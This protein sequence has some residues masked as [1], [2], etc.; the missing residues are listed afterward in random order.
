MISTLTAPSPQPLLQALADE[1]RLR[2]LEAL[3]GGESCVC[4]LQAR[5]GLGQSLLSH[6][7]G[8]LREAGLVADRRDGR[9]VHYSLVPE[10]LGELESFI[11]SLR[12][13]AEHPSG[14]GRRSSCPA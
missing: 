6:H 3:R 10:G 9:W 7:L 11:G 14:A 2:I 1:N 13:A 12:Q 8:V 4:D 5:L